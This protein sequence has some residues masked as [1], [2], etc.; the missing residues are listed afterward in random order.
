MRLTDGWMCW[1][2]Q[3]DPVTGGKHRVHTLEEA[4]GIYFVCPKCATPSK[5]EPGKFSGHPILVWFA[6]RPRVPKEAEPLPRWRVSGTGI[7]DLT[8]FPS[9]LLPSGCR[10]HGW[11]KNGATVT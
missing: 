11:V 10:W 9:I 5:H 7:N 3:F 1:L 8:L 2:V 4:D 6:D